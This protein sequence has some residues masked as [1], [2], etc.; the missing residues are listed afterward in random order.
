MMKL[1]PLCW[2]LCGLLALPFR[3]R[4][5]WR[6]FWKRHP[7]MVGVPRPWWVVYEREAVELL[8]ERLREEALAKKA[9]K[10]P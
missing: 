1:V 8:R 6:Y 3:W 5:F 4:A 9:A 2:C 10:Q 7:E